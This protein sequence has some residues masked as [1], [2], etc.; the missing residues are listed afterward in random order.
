MTL[1][2]FCRRLARL[3]PLSLL[4]LPLAALP[5]RAATIVYTVSTTV[6]STFATNGVLQTNSVIGTI[7][8][9]GTI[10]VLS[11]ADIVSYNLNLIDTL[12]PANDTTLT[13]ANSTNVNLIGNALTATA[14]GLF[15]NFAQT[16]Q[17]YIGKTTGLIPNNYFCFGT[18]INCYPGVSIVPDSLFVDGA[19]ATGTSAPT[20]ILALNNPNP[21][22]PVIPTPVPEPSTYGL[23]LTGLLGLGG[24]V[25][26]KFFA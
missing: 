4:A 11:A 26:R 20:G 7:T 23:V 24:T 1:P 16:G 12:T 17:L 22:V 21:L 25:K 14:S 8:T 3:L 15:F 5:A 9:D 6:S 19:V 10:G 18:G 2:I 13:G